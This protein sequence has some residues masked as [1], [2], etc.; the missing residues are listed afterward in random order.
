M[1]W[2]LI[3]PAWKVEGLTMSERLVL[4]ALVSFT[5]EAGENAYPSQATLARR[6]C[7]DRRTIQRAI[8]SLVE[9]GFISPHGKGIKGTIMYRVNLSPD[10]KGAAQSRMGGWHSVREERHSDTRRGGTVTYNPSKYIPSENPSYRNP[11]NTSRGE[12]FDSDSDY[13]GPPLDEWGRNTE[14]IHDQAMRLD[15]ARRRQR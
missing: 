10:V 2:R 15:R 11:S 8:K 12:Y 3:G 7:C 13:E 6:C 1:T 14:S 4:L 5:N 9:R